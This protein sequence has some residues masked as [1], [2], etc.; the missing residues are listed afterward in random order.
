VRVFLGAFL[1]LW[2]ANKELSDGVVV[3]GET[4]EVWT[5]TAEPV[6]A[7]VRDNNEGLFTKALD[8]PNEAATQKAAIKALRSREERIVILVRCF[9]AKTIYDGR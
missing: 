5:W 8:P 7:L 4:K 6:W 9:L 1:L 3:A 2:R